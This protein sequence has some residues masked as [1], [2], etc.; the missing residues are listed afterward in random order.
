MRARK[1]ALRGARK[2]SSMLNDEH[3]NGNRAAAIVLFVLTALA[4]GSHLLWGQ[5]NLKGKWTTLP[6]LMPINPVHM[7]LLNNGKV[8]VVAGSG[9]VATETN[10]RAALW[11]PQTGS[12][13]TQPLTWDMFCNAM[14]VLPDGRVFVNG[15]TIQYDP[16]KGQPKNAVYDPATG[17]FTDVQ[18]MAHGRWYP[19]TT[20]LGDGRVLTFSGLLETSGTNTTVEIFTAGSGWSPQYSAGWTP[21]LYPRLHLL[22]NGNVF[23]SGSGTGSRT[24][25]TTSN[26]WSAVMATT[27]YPNSR[28]YGTSVLLPLTPANGYRPRVMIF[29][30][31]NPATA[32]TEIIDLGASTPQWQYGPSM[33]QPRIEMNATILPNGKILATGGST[34]DEDTATASYNADLYDPNSNSFSSADVNAFPRLYHSGSLLLPDGTVALAGGNPSRVSYKQHLEISPPAYLFNA[35]GSAATRPTITSLSG[36]TFVYGAGFQIQTPDAANITSVVLVRPGAPTHAFDMDQRLV[37]LSYTAGAGVLNVTAP[38]N[39]NIAP[40]GY[41]MLFI[42]NSAGVPSIAPFVRLNPNQVP[43]ATITSP[44]N[45]VTINAG[46]SVSFAGSGSDSDG[47]ISAYSWS[48]PGGNPASSTVANPGNV[49]YATPGTY[50][51][52]LRVTDNVGAVSPPASRTITVADF[53]LS[54]TPASQTVSAGG[55]TN[56]TTTVT[57]GA[58]FNGTVTFNVTG[59]P[60]GATATFNPASVTGSGS[61]TLSVSTAISTP[62]GSYPLTIT[63][64]SGS[65]SHTANVTLVVTVADFSLSATPASQ[66]VSAGTAATYTA[67][68]TPGTGFNG[69]V[70]FDVTGLP[71][72]ASASFNPATINTSGSTTLNVTTSITTPVGSYPLTITGTS[73]SLSHTTNVTLVVNGDFSISVTPASRT[74]SKGGDAIYTVTVTGAPGFSGTVTLSATNVAAAKEKFSPSSIV[75]SGNS[76]LTI[77]TN[78]GAATGTTTITITGTSGTRVH[79]TTATLV[80]Q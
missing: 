65:L 63:G 79:S 70:S 55:G 72:G 35:D 52:S 66:T 30:G 77:S 34:N 11:D 20:T 28:S 50:T 4:L 12:I 32:T 69:T 19:T 59:L 16:F 76:T 23:Y 71:A 10:Y 29:G 73:G 36:S 9:N 26:T 1:H 5:V 39:G 47:S 7:A 54:A 31:G 60:A 15:G 51:A 21:P 24:F 49:V 41:Y 57:A 43:T 33:S 40:P 18:N 2:D 53:S 46:D 48:F 3:R 45:S 56:Y 13:T 8:L 62:A 37:G 27:N 25:N 80:V 75:N 42:L 67:T 64:T 14:V 61:T 44:A 68:V 58:G 38:P 78:K 6:Y 17:I 74:V 22:P